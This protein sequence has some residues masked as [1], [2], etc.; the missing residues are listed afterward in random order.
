MN[1]EC[2]LLKNSKCSVYDIRPISCSTHFVTSD[3]RLCD[4]WSAETGSYIPYDFDDIR[5]QAENK[6]NSM[7]RSSGLLGVKLPIASALLFAEYSRTVKARTVEQ[8]WEVLNEE[9]R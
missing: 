8:L 5:E 4:P 7:F 1:I 6:I 9:F 2:P 3:P